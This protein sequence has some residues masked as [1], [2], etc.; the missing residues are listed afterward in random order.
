MSD[1]QAIAETMAT[2]FVEAV[3]ATKRER[4]AAV[5]EVRAAIDQAEQTRRDGLARVRKM[6]EDAGALIAESLHEEERIEASYREARDEVDQLLADLE[7]PR[8]E[9]RK[10]KALKGGKDA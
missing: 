2:D 5:Q 9:T 6:R 1:I 8:L 10:L 7:R 3:K 4:A